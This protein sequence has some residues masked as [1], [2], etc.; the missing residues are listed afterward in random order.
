M[1]LYRLWQLL[2]QLFCNDVIFV[3]ELRHSG[4]VDSGSHPT[5][6]SRPIHWQNGLPDHQDVEMVGR[7]LSEQILDCGGPPQTDGSSW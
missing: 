7:I 4:V 5:V 3:P 2:T 1:K 6:G